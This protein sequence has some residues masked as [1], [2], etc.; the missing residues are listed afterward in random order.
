MIRVNRRR[1]ALA[2]A[3]AALLALVA[4]GASAPDLGDAPYPVGTGMDEA[5]D[6]HMQGVMEAGS[7]TVVTDRARYAV[8]YREGVFRGT[9]NVTYNNGVRSSAAV[10][11]ELG[12]AAYLKGS[13][14]SG[15][16]RVEKPSL[17]LW[18]PTIDLGGF[19]RGG[20]LLLGVD[21][22]DQLMKNLEFTSVDERTRGGRTTYVYRAD[23]FS[24]EV[25]LYTGD[26]GFRVEDVE[27]SMEV[28]PGGLV[29]SYTLR[30]T[31]RDSP[32]GSS[33]IE[34]RVVYKH[35]GATEVTKPGWVGTAVERT[36]NQSD[37]GS[38]ATETY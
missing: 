6:N 15:Y 17:H 22:G 1:L 25:F 30:V 20:G 11:G 29:R 13:L 18:F 31:Y 26:Q 35:V 23:R 32:D 5:L 10:Y 3:V 36:R 19:S 27:A 2:A 14:V 21:E 7:V 37:N 33:T 28:L 12:R 4:F 34:K 8:D 9:Q 24:G 38:A 16:R